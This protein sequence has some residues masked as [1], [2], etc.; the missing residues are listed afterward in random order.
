MEALLPGSSILAAFVGGMLALAAPCCITF[1]LPSYLAGVYRAR[2]A[3]LAMTFVFGLGI[4][5]VI[6]PIALGVSALARLISEW[7]V[8]VFILGGVFLLFLG[9]WSL[10]GRNIALPFKPKASAA[11]AGVFSVFGLGVF[12]GAASSCCA[13]VL[14]GVLTLTALTATLPQAGA[15]AL[16]Y[17]FGMVFPLLVAGYL[18]D[19]FDLS[20]N[21]IFRGRPLQFRAG[22]FSY[23]IHSTNLI[24]GLLFWAMGLLI[25]ALTFT[26]QLTDA[27]EAQTS[28]YDQLNATADWLTDSLGWLPGVAT[29]LLLV[30]AFLFLLRAALRHPPHA[31]AAVG[32]GG[33][34]DGLADARAD[35]PKEA[36]HAGEG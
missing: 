23:R 19:R 26:G 6:L 36:C 16:A 31:A 24:A 29:A 9:T 30:A 25:L 3:V 32:D 20:S 15:V 18:W 8:E 12:S 7:H 34:I 35:T 13:P 5:V 22:G 4:A 27:T 11:G 28:I 14:V 17:V 2:V 1:L 33:E 10:M 21:F